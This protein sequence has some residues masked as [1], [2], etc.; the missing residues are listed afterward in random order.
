MFHSHVVPVNKSRVLSSFNGEG[1]FQVTVA[2]SAL[3]VGINF[4][5]VSQVVMYGLPEDPEAT[6]QQVGRAGR[7]GSPAHSV[8]YTNKKLANTDNAV[9][10]VLQESLNGCFRKA[11]YSHFETDVSSVE[12]G[13]SYCTFGHSLCKCSSV[14]TP[15]YEMPKQ[16]SSPVKCKSH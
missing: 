10:R 1:S 4:P 15:N 14:P 3:G 6:L 16:V 13:H 12:P 7:D 9:K 11:L 8:C 2:T 5:K